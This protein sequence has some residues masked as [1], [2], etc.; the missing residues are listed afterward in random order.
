MYFENVGMYNSALQQFSLYCFYYFYLLLQLFILT[1][2]I[3]LMR[4]L[5][6][7]SGKYVFFFLFSCIAF[8]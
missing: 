4:K 7:N 6:F 1:V 8:I 2:L 5:N 3:S